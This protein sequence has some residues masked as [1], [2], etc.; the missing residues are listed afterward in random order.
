MNRAPH[1]FSLRQLQ[2]AIAVAD[3]L[4]FRHAAELCHVS[5]PALSIQLAQLES[6]LGV[7]L[8]DRD[9]RTVRLT[10][11][12]AE[13]I[14]RARSMTQDADALACAAQARQDPLSGTLRFGIIPTMSPYFLPSIAAAFRKAHPKL[15]ARW[16]EERTD[17]LVRS[18]EHGELDAAFVALE[19]PLGDL[20]HSVVG[21]DAFVL[22]ASKQ[23]PL[24]AQQGS[25]KASD[26]RNVDVLLLEDGHCFREQ[27][28]AFC[29]RGRARELEFRATS[30]PTL[31][32]MVASGAGVTLL[33]QMAVPTEGKG[34]RI[35]RFVQ[36]APFRT[37]ALVW[38]K[39]SALKSALETLTATAKGAYEAVTRAQK[40]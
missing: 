5:Q 6:A 27:A 28:L 22:A 29:S 7:R 38:R 26:L 9:Q 33:P 23:H 1:P 34:L 16:V 36:P 12:G 31:V 14:E 10:S 18:I 37:L 24:G 15:N 17:V 21:E 13:L 19:A 4:S 2:Y 32:Q 30:L 11:T 3:T 8:F 20:V 40:V 39:R 35:R 25:V